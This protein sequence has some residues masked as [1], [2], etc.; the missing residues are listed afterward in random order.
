M[1]KDR[2]A[3]RL[4]ELCRLVLNERDYSGTAGPQEFSPSKTQL[5]VPSDLKNVLGSSPRYVHLRDDLP[6]SRVR[7][8]TFV[9]LII[10]KFVKPCLSRLQAR[11]NGDSLR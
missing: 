10:R 11:D 5:L 6:R 7:R 4:G 1:K 2:S 8:K 3:E 9:A